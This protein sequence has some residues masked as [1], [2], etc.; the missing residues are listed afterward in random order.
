M[1]LEQIRY[2]GIEKQLYEIIRGKKKSLNSLSSKFTEMTTIA[3]QVIP[4]IWLLCDNF[5]KFTH[6]HKPTIEEH[7]ASRWYRFIGRF[8]KANFS[9]LTQN[10]IFR[11]EFVCSHYHFSEISALII[12][13]KILISHIIL[14][15]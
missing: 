1:E 13:C 2:I 6:I 7:S 12:E 11:N 5:E 15:T 10:Q 9:K 14:C 3:N 4:E 8:I